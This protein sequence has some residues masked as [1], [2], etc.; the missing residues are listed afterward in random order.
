MRRFGNWCARRN[1]SKAAQHNCGT[2]AALESSSGLPLYALRRSLRPVWHKS[3][4][5]PILQI[6]VANNVLYNEDTSDVSKFAT[7]PK[8]TVADSHSAKNFNRA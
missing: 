2:T 1:R 6:D 7:D 4:Q 8:A 3:R 5:L